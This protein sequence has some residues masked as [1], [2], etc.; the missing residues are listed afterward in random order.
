M[1][2]FCFSSD[3][4]HVEK[5]LSS[6]SSQHRTDRP[7]LMAQGHEIIKTID[8]I[9]GQNTSGTLGKSPFLLFCAG[10][11]IC[12][13][14]LCSLPLHFIF[15]LYLCSA[16]FYTNWMVPAFPECPLNCFLTQTNPN[17]NI[18]NSFF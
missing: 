10:S 1:A 8:L 13:T 2:R 7:T 18:L 11:F 17:T 16:P 14:R 4:L 9:P 15:L 3:S 5:S 6:V 12:K